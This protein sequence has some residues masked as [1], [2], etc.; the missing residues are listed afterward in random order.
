MQIIHLIDL[1]P[2]IKNNI[3]LSTS[4]M[5]QHCTTHPKK[6]TNIPAPSAVTNCS[7]DDEKINFSCFHFATLINYKT[8]ALS[9]FLSKN[10]RGEMNQRAIPLW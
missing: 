10:K 7:H 8:H 6:K 9:F 2:D 3:A 4:Q 5:V 1:H